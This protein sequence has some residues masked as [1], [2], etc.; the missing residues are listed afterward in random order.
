MHTLTDCINE[1]NKCA[2][3]IAVAK[4]KLHRDLDTL[5]EETKRLQSELGTLNVL[6]SYRTRSLSSKGT[7][8]RFDIDGKQA[9]FYFPVLDKQEITYDISEVHARVTK[10]KKL[11]SEN[12]VWVEHALLETQ[13][14]YTAKWETDKLLV[15]I[16][17][18]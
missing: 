7:G 14:D 9:A 15:D 4:R 11:I 2:E 16:L 3:A 12:K 17:E 18:G 10:L 1:E 13:V 8:Y 6:L 5:V